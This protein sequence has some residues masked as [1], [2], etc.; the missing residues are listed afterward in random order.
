MVNG[1]FC[2]RCRP[3]C[4]KIASLSLFSSADNYGDLPPNEVAKRIKFYTVRQRERIYTGY[5]RKNAAHVFVI[6]IDF[7]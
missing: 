6:S 2:E 7:Y 4:I 1:L 3:L 5:L